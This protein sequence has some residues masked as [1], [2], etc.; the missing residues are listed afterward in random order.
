L[1]RVEPQ[2]N[3]P[4]MKEMKKLKVEGQGSRSKL[5]NPLKWFLIGVKREL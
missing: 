2:T 5:K 1:F 3:G 4:K